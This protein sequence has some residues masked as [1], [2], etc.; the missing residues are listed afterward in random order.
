MAAAAAIAA[1]V[2]A[3]PLATATSASATTYSCGTNHIDSGVCLFYNS[4]AYGYGAGFE[5]PFNIPDYA[6]YTFT[7]SS[8][9]SA[10]SGSPVKNDAAALYNYTTDIFALFYNSY[11]NCSVACDTFDSGSFRDFN[12]ALHNENASGELA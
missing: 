4:K 2:V 1:S 9:G 3:A 11:Y 5:Q 10:G 8:Y 12:P 6:G 7:T